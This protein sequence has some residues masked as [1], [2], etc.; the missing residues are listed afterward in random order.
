M[1]VH[2]QIPT[3]ALRTD[4]IQRFQQIMIYFAVSVSIF[5]SCV[6]QHDASTGIMDGKQLRV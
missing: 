4:C 6:S 2:D 1:F 3:D 5:R